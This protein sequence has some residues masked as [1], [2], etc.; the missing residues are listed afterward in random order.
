LRRARSQH[1]HRRITCSAALLLTA[2]QDLLCAISRHL[3]AAPAASSCAHSRLY[4]AA[5]SCR[6]AHRHARAPSPSERTAPPAPRLRCIYRA[7]ARP[8]A[9]LYSFHSIARTLI[10]A[11]R[12][13]PPER[14]LSPLTLTSSSHAPASAHSATLPACACSP[15]SPHAPVT[16]HLPLRCAATSPPASFSPLAPHL[17]SYSATLCLLEGWGWRR[18]LAPARAVLRSGARQEEGHSAHNA[19]L[20]AALCLLLLRGQSLTRI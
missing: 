19:P 6:N 10:S 9:R 16:S 8:L 1:H 13:E 4:R 7:R 17:F 18:A 2:A 12:R 3:C 14:R 20:C 11:L 15:A 5:H